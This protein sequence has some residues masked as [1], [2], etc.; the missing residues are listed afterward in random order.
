M[1]TFL[2]GR[3]ANPLKCA[4]AHPRVAGTAGPEAGRLKNPSDETS[5]ES[6]WAP[7]EEGWIPGVSDLR[8]VTSIATA[9]GGGAL[10]GAAC[11]LCL[12]AAGG[13][14]AAARRGEQR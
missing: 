11:A 2:G 10:R 12:G 3:D 5:K 4:F 8:R 13:N 14:T 1:L 6:A 9:G 7:P